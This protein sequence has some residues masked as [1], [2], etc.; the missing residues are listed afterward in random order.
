M[1]GRLVLLV[2]IVMALGLASAPAVLADT[3]IMADESCRTDVREPE[4][5][6]HDSSK[7]SVRSD[8]K[9]AKS[10]I[11]FDIS[12]LLV[13]DLETATLTVALHQEKASDR[14][15]DVSY[16]NDDCLDNIDWD[17]R[18]LTWNNAPGNNPDDLTA[19]DTG[20][21][22]LLGTVNFTD[23][24]P[25][26][27]FTID[28][29]EALQTDTDGIVQFVCHNS[30][31]LLHL[32]THDHAQEAWRPFLTAS[33]GARDKAKKPYPPDG[34]TDVCLAPVLGWTP[35]AYVEG[36][37]PK[38]KVFFSEDFSDVNDGIG[39]VTQD[40]SDYP[41]P[42]S[43]LD[44]GTTY[45]WRVDEANDVSGW[46]PG[47]VWEFTTEPV[48]YPIPAANITV[49]ASSM[50]SSDANPGNTIDGSGLGDDDRHS[51]DAG[52]MWLSGPAEPNQAWI[53]YEF[54]KPYKLRQ[55][56]V[57]NYNGSSFLS[58]TGMKEVI[59]EYSENGEAWTPLDGVSE[60]AQAPG[61]EDYATDI[62]LDF[63]GV[64]ARYVRITAQSNWS[65]GGVLDQY[66][67]SEV[68]F[69]YLPVRARELS[70]AA[71]S[72]NVDPT[73]E[74]RW[75]AGRLAGVHEV[76]LGSDPNDLA[77]ADVVTGWPYAA[78][79]TSPLDLQ[80]GQ[81][82]YWQVNEVNEAELPD[83]WA[84]DVA[85]FSTR[86]FLVVDDFEGYTNDPIAF[87]RVFQ[88]WIDGAGYT[89][90]VE[91]AGNGT[92]SYIGHD[93]QLGDIMEKDIVHGGVQSA[94]IYYGNG[95]QRISEVDCTF[96]EPQD[97]TRAGVQTLSI[98]FHGAAGNTGQLYVKINGTR[99]DYDLDPADLAIAAWQAW[100]IDLATVPANLQ[101]VTKLTIGV[102]GAGTG[103]FYID[104]IRLYAE[105]AELVTPAAPDTAN[106]L[107][108][109]PFEGN[110][111]DSSGNG[112]H[113]TI[114]DGQIV[115]PGKVGNSAVQLSQAGYVD[116]GNPALLDFGTGDWAVTAWFKTTMT[117]TE[118]GDRGAIYGNGGDGNGGHR[119]A[120]ILSESNEG[121]VSL[122]CDDDATKEQAHSTSTTNN[123]EWHCV[124]GQRE[125]T[126]IRIFIDGHLEASNTVEADYNLS[127]TSQHNAY[128]G[129]ITD[130]SSGSLFKSFKGFI[131]EVRIY[132]R[133]LS[134]EEVLWLAGRTTPIH[135]PL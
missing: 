118:E 135:K 42:G 64:V 69:L 112:L 101:N 27:A 89:V 100:N 49:T 91:V 107:A 65:P 79:D 33:E 106:L 55:M 50:D 37:S 3:I 14:H 97:W 26:D 116:L 83:T 8:E 25:G 38:H 76:Y 117:G 86:Q 19:L 77:L 54:D 58:W 34:A 29:L 114:T 93:P 7:L 60:F 36:L 61:T 39:G 22:T 134:T 95:G 98:A 96:D 72:T 28:V 131:D 92:G 41:V 82:Y 129:A 88:T 63:A 123:D 111:N 62:V 109:Y 70:P 59:V 35:G 51:T 1:S 71:G 32:A 15:F 130:N 53:E 121:A 52:A 20:K 94:P 12:E 75:R 99:V 128:I 9:S 43:P 47:D 108:H 74:L 110:A 78:Y 120:L 105:T 73:V 16:V 23:G 17:E 67:L 40:A 132:D 45:Y 126:S 115:S 81:G 68:R 102:E 127:G 125:G 87:R 56:L 5:N 21:T 84:G 90:P 104:D 57:W 30:N 6:K 11:K 80:L 66:G 18:S 124:V 10:W 46:D 44:F 85:G 103:I 122:V 13:E 31:G 119:I 113:G 24:V 48:S 133:A 2:G 4:T